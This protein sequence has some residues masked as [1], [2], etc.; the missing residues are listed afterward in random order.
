MIILMFQAEPAQNGHMVDSDGVLPRLRDS[1]D[2]A[3]YPPGLGV[4]GGGAALLRQQ[5][6]RAQAEALQNLRRAEAAERQAAAGKELLAL[7][8]RRLA[9]A[10]AACA[11]VGGRLHDGR[12]ERVR[13]LWFYAAHDK[14]RVLCM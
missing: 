13:E 10:E 9:R 8:E 12:I 3:L 14:S 11:Q 1:V 4:G 6:H 7:A 5:L 2:S